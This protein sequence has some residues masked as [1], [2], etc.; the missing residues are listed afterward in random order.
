MLENGQNGQVRNLSLIKIVTISMNW[1]LENR[2]KLII[3]N[4]D[5]MK[6]ISLAITLLIVAIIGLAACFQ[7]TPPLD[8]INTVYTI[9]YLKSYRADLI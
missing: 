1:C 4:I 5:S 6:K 7:T 8:S 3:N 9:P 2:Y